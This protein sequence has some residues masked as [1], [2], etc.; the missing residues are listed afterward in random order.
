MVNHIVTL[1]T[2]ILV[3]ILVYIR[4]SPKIIFGRRFKHGYIVKAVGDSF[5]EVG[6]CRKSGVQNPSKKFAA[7]NIRS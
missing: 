1:Q 6:C 2:S 7:K 5:S 4:M 3:C